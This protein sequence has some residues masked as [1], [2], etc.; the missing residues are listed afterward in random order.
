MTTIIQ[1]TPAT[2]LALSVAAP[3]A[4]LLLLYGTYHWD[5]SLLQSCLI[6]GVSLWLALL[7]W[8][9]WSVRGHRARAV[10]G[11]VYLPYCSWQILHVVSKW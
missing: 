1:K 3:G 9:L 8:S 4:A 5:E 11:S 2:F 6:L 7:G 10:F